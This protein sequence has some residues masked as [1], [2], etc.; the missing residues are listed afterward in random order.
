MLSRL[1][2]SIIKS[3]LKNRI[4]VQGQGGREYQT[5]GA[6][7]ANAHRGKYIGYFEDLIQAPNAE[8]G[9]KD[10]VEMAFSL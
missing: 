9:L 5:G 4:L 7:E 8:I 10:F 6:R 1:I 3:Y 2:F